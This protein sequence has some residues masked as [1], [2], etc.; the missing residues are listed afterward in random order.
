[1]NKVCELCGATSEMDFNAII[2]ISEEEAVLVKGDICF[3]CFG[4]YLDDMAV[5]VALLE[6]RV[7][8]QEG[9]LTTAA[10]DAAG[11]ALVEGQH[12]TP[13]EPLE[14]WPHANS[15]RR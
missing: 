13:D 3:S 2:P 5:A 10:P 7:Q 14:G 11:A 12:L 9:G 4:S 6:K 8:Q 1:M 15:P